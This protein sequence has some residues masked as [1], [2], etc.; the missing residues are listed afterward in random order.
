[1]KPT[2]AEF[3]RTKA[4]AL[5]FS[6]IGFAPAESMEDE[7]VHLREWLDRN[8]HATMS[9]MERGVEKRADVRHI[10]PGARSVVSLCL[11]Y[12]TGARHSADHSTGKI[13]R[14]AWGDDYHIVMTARLERLLEEICAV[15]PGIHG[16][17]Y[18]D[19]GPVMEKVWAAKAGL[20][21]QGKHTNLITKEF[22]SWVFL[23]EILLDRELEYDAPVA[24]ACGTCTACI[25]ACPTNAIVA[26][27]VL[28]SAR[29]ISYLT[30]EHRG[31]ISP[32]LGNKLEGWIYGCDICQDVCPWN[33]FQ[34]VTDVR[35]FEPREWN[36]APD[37][38]AVAALTND[39]FRER[40][41]RS[42][43]KRTKREG[44]ARNAELN[45]QAS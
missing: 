45:L 33:R 23:G 25:D 32:E 41:R 11:N 43:V 6:G 2:L 14:Y 7:T 21:W 1:M 12:Y 18:V 27:Y 38:K 20:G 39:E 17:V 34:K 3:I 29:C 30:I 9:W 42:P 5:G 26:P 16:K 35:E 22:G 31:P 15:E 4:L 28:D 19:T 44:L 24:D 40:F 37:L 36:I 8:L 10:L 13:S